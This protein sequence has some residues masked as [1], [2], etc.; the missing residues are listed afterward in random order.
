MEGRL[1][2]SAFECQSYS[3]LQNVRVTS[4]SDPDRDRFR[5]WPTPA[6]YT[7]YT[8]AGVVLLLVLALIAGMIVVRRPLP[9]TT[10]DLRLKGL[11]DTVQVRRDGLGVPQIYAGTSHDLFYAQGFVQAQDRF[12]QMDYRRHLSAGRLSE[13]FGARTLSS[14]MTA[15]T[16]GWYR[17]AEREYQLVSAE[18]REAL[19]SY[20]DGVNA[21]LSSHSGSGASLEYTVLSVAVDYRPEPWTPVD[22]LAWLKSMA[23]DLAGN[24]ED[25]IARARLSIDRD[26]AQVAE[27]YPSYPYAER[28]PIVDTQRSAG[29]AARPAAMPAWR[30]TGA[31]LRPLERVA[32]STREFPRTV[33]SGDGLGSNGWVVAGSHTTTGSP[34]L[35][36]D[37]HLDVGQPG[38]FYQ[39]GLHCRTVGDSCPYDVAGFS[40]AGFPGIAIGHN[41]DIAW[42]MTNLR[43]DTTDLYL[44]KVTGKDYLYDARRLPMEERDERIRIAGGDSK[45][46]TVRSTRHGPL[47]SDVSRELSSVGAN[48]P[49]PTDAPERG[50][51]YAVAVDWTASTPGTSTDALLAMNRAGDWAAFRAAAADL[52]APATSLVYSDSLG[53]IGYQAAGAVPIR[54]AGHTGD[55]PAAGW[56]K[57]QDWTG[58]L[59][60]ATKLPTEFNP[61]SGVIVAANQAVTGPSYPY[62]LADWFDYGYRS[63]RI[64]RLLRAGVADGAK[65]R[66]A[67]MAGIQN[68]T[69]NPM[70]PVLAPYLLDVLLPSAYYAS[71]QQLLSGW[72]YTQPDDS[73]AAAYFN[74]VW[75]MVLELTFHDQLRESLWPD[76]SSRWMAVMTRLLRHPDS[77]WW[78]D[79]DTSDVVENRDVI[80]GKAMQEARDELVRL[81]SR[82]PK[83]WTWGH[84]HQLRLDRPTFSSGSWMA[85]ALFDRHGHGAPGGTGAVNATAWDPRAGYAVTS[86]PAM[87]MVVD[88]GDLDRSRWVNLAGQSGHAFDEHYTDQVDLWLDGRTAPWPFSGAAVRRATDDTLVLRP[89]E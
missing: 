35:A 3:A 55:Y 69:R 52:G 28:A 26:P 75:R 81:Q 67:D 63:N 46:I 78:D 64:H 16:L 77:P 9:Q 33:G 6:R 61:A 11:D 10:G 47:V 36:N 50:N 7:V 58:K 5:D 51:G 17:T 20:S 34:L 38:V 25:E 22:S 27:L 87:R 48:A 86:A 62:R 73:A 29:Q 44:E 32:R 89:E 82:D 65:L 15:R 79:V 4:A 80:L 57:S 30:I 71:G 1:A 8:V 70:G 18:A 56:E 53:N 54:R 84:L 68:D 19:D 43:A 14:D 40:W 2:L 41:D 23:W 12:W 74:A 39:M 21:W 59:V 72:D 42:G 83:R 60:P 24:V 76:G 85:G 66:A 49:A 88:L 45:L 31:M 37:P 13:L